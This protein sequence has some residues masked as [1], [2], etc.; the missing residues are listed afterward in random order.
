MKKVFQKNIDKDNGDCIQAAI[1]S[2]FELDMEDVPKFIEHGTKWFEVFWN[3]LKEHGYEYH[4]MRNNHIYDYIS[5]PNDDCFKEVKRSQL[6]DN[7]KDIESVNGVYHAS[8][9]SPKYFSWQGRWVTH[10]VLIDSDFN[11]LHDPSPAYQNIR[12]YPLADVIGYNG[13]INYYMIEKSK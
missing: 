11:I 3:F 10:S 6:L 1:A 2:M 13:V 4:G 8:V 7:I 9:L 12:Q 5:N